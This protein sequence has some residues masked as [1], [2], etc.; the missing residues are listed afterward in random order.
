MLI[1]FLTNCG[2]KYYIHHVVNQYTRHL[3]QVQQRFTELFRTENQLH[4]QYECFTC[5]TCLCFP[6]V[7]LIDNLFL[8]KV[9]S[10]IELFLV[11]KNVKGRRRE[12]PQNDRHQAIGVL[13]SRMTVNDVAVSF[14]VHRTTIW[15]LA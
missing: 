12:L 14:G 9:Q 4:V 10:R 7:N 2:Y 13:E 8:S 3:K 5:L 15:R 1:F 11:T 6:K